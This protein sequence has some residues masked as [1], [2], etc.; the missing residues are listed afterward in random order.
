M[1]TRLQ[2]RTPPHPLGDP[3]K[4]RVLVIGAGVAGLEVAKGLRTA[5]CDVLVIDQHNHYTFQALLYQVA[6]AHLDAGDIARPVRAILQEIPNARFRHGTVHAVDWTAR[7]VQLADGARLPFDHLV[8]AAGAIYADFGVPGVRKH[9]HFL[10]SVSEAVNLRSDILL[11][12]EEAAAQPHRMDDGTLTFTIVGGGPTGVE[13]AGALAELVDDA[14]KRDYPELD[15]S[16]VR[17]TLLEMGDGLLPAFSDKSRAHARE[18]L[19]RRGVEVRLGTTVQEVHADAVELDTGERLPTRTVVWAAGVRAHPL[20]ETLGTP[21]TRGGRLEILDDL[22]LPG[23]PNAWA[24]GDVAAG[25]SSDGA[26]LPQVAPAAIQH[27]KHIARNIRARLRNEPTTPFRYFDKGNM[28]IIGRNAGIAEASK[29]LGGLHF[30]GFIGWL[31]WLLLHLVYLPGHRNRL[32]AFTAWAYHYVTRDRHARLITEMRHSPLAQT[33]RRGR[34]P[35]PPRRAPGTA[36]QAHPPHR[37]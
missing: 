14:M 7:E 19:E 1:P 28:A 29:R 10:K 15:L 25:K 12:F 18:V 34:L 37:T 6:S 21:T 33:G 27:G 22:S 2:D 8:V 9:A 5:P 3:A 24:A 26:L 36:P 16:Q 20:A 31:A 23:H 17:I 35:H 4:P 30:R 11:R 13:M 32:G